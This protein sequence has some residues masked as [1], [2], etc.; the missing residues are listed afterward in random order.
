MKHLS[1]AELAFFFRQLQVMTSAGISVAAAL[2]ILSRDVQSLMKRQR[3][4]Q[5]LRYMEKGKSFSQAMEQTGLFPV[6]ACRI[7]YAG[8]QAGQLDDMFGLVSHYYED[9]QKQRQALRQAL[10]YPVFLLACTILLLVGAVFGIVPVFADMFHEFGI[11]LPP[12]IKALLSIGQVLREY[13]MII[14]VGCIC[15]SILGVYSWQDQAYRLAIVRRIFSLAWCRRVGIILCWQRFS[16]LLG[17]QIRSGIPLLEAMQDAAQAVRLVWF[18][19]EIAACC[20]LMEQGMS[21]SQA[22]AK[23]HITTPYITTMLVVG[24]TTGTYDETLQAITAYYTWHIQQF[25]QQLQQYIG[26]AVLLLAGI[27][28][29]TLMVCLLVPLLDMA[30]GAGL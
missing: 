14:A 28:I 24:E 21:L 10:A 17:M 8:E 5:A 4:Q 18:R 6:L 25:L 19:Q 26:P 2:D 11:P 20:Q 9:V 27:A 16:Q 15:L 3:L 12:A 1:H 22:A 7:I 13:G 23:R 30:A 29:G